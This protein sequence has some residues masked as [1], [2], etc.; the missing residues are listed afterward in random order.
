LALAG[1]KLTRDEK[2][3]DAIIRGVYG[4]EQDY[5]SPWYNAKKAECFLEI[6][7]TTRDEKWLL[8]A[9]R[10]LS[11]TL[12]NFVPGKGLLHSIQKLG[13]KWVEIDLPFLIVPMFYVL[14]V[15]ERISGYEKFNVDTGIE[16]WLLSTQLP[17]GYFRNTNGYGIRD[18][19]GSVAW[20]AFAFDFLSKQYSFQTA[21]SEFTETLI[22]KDMYTVHETRNHLEIYLNDYKFIEICKSTG[23][24]TKFSLLPSQISGHIVSKSTHLI[25]DTHLTITRSER[26][27]DFGFIDA[28]GK[29]FLPH[30]QGRKNLWHPKETLIT[31]FKGNYI[32]IQAKLITFNK[33]YHS[34]IILVYFM[35]TRMMLRYNMFQYFCKWKFWFLT[36]VFRLR[37]Q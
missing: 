27:V 32:S 7:L 19:I 17:S 8:R 21:I 13:D 10:C 26:E 14:N 18:V 11:F 3:K 1:D 37:S 23:S 12:A 4:K 25:S 24:I 15:A 9:K 36:K 34:P 30:V 35:L 28:A 16:K 2:L 33:I 20:N 6:F 29:Y 22:S 5:V 31:Y